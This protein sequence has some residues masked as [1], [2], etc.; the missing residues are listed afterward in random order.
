M[1]AQPV[2]FVQSNWVDRSS[3]HSLG[4][5]MFFK[6][7][8]G[9][10]G[11]GLLDEKFINRRISKTMTIAERQSKKSVKLL[12]LGGGTLSSS[13]FSTNSAHTC[14]W[15]RQDHAAQAILS[16]VQRRFQGRA[17]SFGLPRS[18]LPQFN[19]RHEANRLRGGAQTR[20]HSNSVDAVPGRRRNDQTR[21][22]GL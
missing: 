4:I 13:H 5:N 14:R 8:S 22:R 7:K 11:S 3:S 6:S 16:L 10:A 2:F 9:S 20:R 12:I 19:R 17:K 1:C 15:K 18:N 21:K